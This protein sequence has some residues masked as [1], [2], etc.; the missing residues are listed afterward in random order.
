MSS[1][2]NK[3][4]I[5]LKIIRNAGKSKLR[6]FRCVF[7]SCVI[8]LVSVLT[9]SCVDENCGVCMK[10]K[11][12]DLLRYCY[13]D[14]DCTCMAD[15]MENSGIPGVSG[16]LDQC[17]LA[18]RPSALYS[19]EECVATACPDT[20]DECS[21]PVGYVI[22]QPEICNASDPDI[23][24]GSLPN[25]S[26]DQNLQFDPGGAI[27][28]LENSDGTVCVRIERRDD[29]AGSLANRNWTL[30]NIRVGPLG[31]VA[32][33]DDGSAQCW[34]SSHHNFKDWVHVWT[35]TKHFDLRLSEDGHGG[36]RAYDLFVFE[37]G[38]VNTTSCAPTAEGSLCINGPIEL[39]P[40]NP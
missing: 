25:C 19:V 30:L 33:V 28:Q 7:Y 1:T 11:C 6:P 39:F 34:Y 15:C 20:G 9:S 4:H 16:C 31:E 21:T 29:G 35:G 14:T 10:E 26:F 38:P 32:L 22:P 37:Q 23:G 3:G 8:L 36:V 5:T 2:T 24:G 17:G 12:S 27:L 40:V 18:E 13:D